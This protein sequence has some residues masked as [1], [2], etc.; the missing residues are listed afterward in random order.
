M[1]ARSSTS[2]VST[3]WPSID[4]PR[5]ACAL[6]AASSGL[7]AIPMPPALPRLPVG[8][9][10]FTTQGPTSWKAAAADAGVAQS[11]PR[12]TGM[13]AGRSTFSLAACSS[14]FMASMPVAGP[15]RPEQRLLAR[16]VLRDRRHEM[17]D[18]EEVPVIQVFGNAVLLPGA[19]AHAQREIEAAVEA[20]AIAEGVGEVHEHA[21]HVEIL[22]QLAGAGEIARMDAAGMAAALM[23]EDAPDLVL[24]GREVRGAVDGQHER[25]LLARERVLA[26]DPG[27]LDHEEAGAFGLRAE[28]EG[29]GQDVGV[30]G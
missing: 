12:G 1:A 7:S 19:A 4:M 23:I 29:A 8:T 13:P 26:P 16:P 30:A 10:A 18:V 9:C 20:A 6:A 5:M 17:R 22:G 21:D 24:G 2:T 11:R 27:L 15:M 28:A 25:E 3:T 14:K